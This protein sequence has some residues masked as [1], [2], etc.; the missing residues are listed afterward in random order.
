MDI[1]QRNDTPGRTYT[2]GICKT[3]VSYQVWGVVTTRGNYD[4]IKEGSTPDLI[5]E[6]CDR[7]DLRIHKR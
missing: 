6:R 2:G 3:G 5:G 4:I 1:R 7:T